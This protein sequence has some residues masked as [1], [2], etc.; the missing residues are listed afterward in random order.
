MQ[1]RLLKTKTTKKASNFRKLDILSPIVYRVPSSLPRFNGG[2]LDGRFHSRLKNSVFISLHVSCYQ[3]YN[4][5]TDPP[6]VVN[7]AT[8]LKD[9]T[10]VPVEYSFFIFLDTEKVRKA[11]L[12]IYFLKPQG[13]FKG[14][15]RFLYIRTPL[16]FIDV[17]QEHVY[18]RSI[19]EINCIHWDRSAFDER[20]RPAFHFTLF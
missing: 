14:K 8:V 1:Q 6:G 15:I 11:I 16:N 3:K 17:L 13:R 18:G 10:V 5:N 7:L 12:Q 2:R 9:K 20:L 4:T 19:F